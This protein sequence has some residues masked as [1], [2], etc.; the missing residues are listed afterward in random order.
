MLIHDT[1]LVS[2]SLE[3]LKKGCKD[4]DPKIDEKTIELVFKTLDY[5]EDKKVTLAGKLT[6]FPEFWLLYSW[7]L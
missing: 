4:K 3:E 5:D 2:L 6:E 1:H 7:V